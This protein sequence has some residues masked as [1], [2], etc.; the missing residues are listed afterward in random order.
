VAN[1]TVET[2][3]EA[4]ALLL[5]LEKR[6]GDWSDFWGIARA[7]IRAIEQKRW[8]S[9]GLGS[10]RPKTLEKR[11][12]REGYYENEPGGGD[13]FA[14]YFWTGALSEAAMV[15]TWTRPMAASIDPHQNYRGP[16]QREMRDPF[17]EVMGHLGESTIWNFANVE[18][19][20]DASIER[21]LEN[22][23]LPR[24]ST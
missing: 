4:T 7:N 6:L 9:G 15:F 1:V 19:A 17:G 22:N 12:D 24:A 14:K 10:V 13:V 8:K 20:L 5:Q 21:W 11:E 2:E 16:L 23:V 3:Q 18:K